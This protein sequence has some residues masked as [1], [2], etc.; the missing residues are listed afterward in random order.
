VA[1]DK[2]A[3]GEEVKPGLAD[4]EITDAC[5]RLDEWWSAESRANSLPADG[6]AG[7]GVALPIAVNMLLV[8]GPDRMC[9]L[10]RADQPLQ[11]LLDRISEGIEDIMDTHQARKA[12]GP[13]CPR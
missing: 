7:A 1:P 11:P 9:L 3:L 4:G 13:R 8:Y 12:I 2:E 10:E 5:I 6:G